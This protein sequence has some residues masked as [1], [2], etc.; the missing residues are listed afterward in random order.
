MTYT[1]KSGA[2]THFTSVVAGSRDLW[3]A[4]WKSAG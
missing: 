2:N 1:S 4:W 3:I